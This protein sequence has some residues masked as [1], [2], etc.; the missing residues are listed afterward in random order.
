MIRVM[1]NL[2][3]EFEL[4]REIE[5]YPQKLQ[6][7]SD[8]LLGLRHEEEPPRFRKT[9][10]TR[11]GPCIQTIPNVCSLLDALQELSIRRHI[12][13]TGK[14]VVNPYPTEY[15]LLRHLLAR[16]TNFRFP[17]LQLCHIHL[18]T[19]RHLD[20]IIEFFIPITTHLV[21]VNEFHRPPR[22]SNFL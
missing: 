8:T 9:L 15:A 20:L 17:T 16:C 21:I 18:G 13:E 12:A 2:K 7:L 11:Y 6:D 5:S 1:I 3:Q 22:I 10:L 14:M 19:L 4:E